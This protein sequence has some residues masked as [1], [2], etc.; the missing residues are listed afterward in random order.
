M[1]EPPFDLLSPEK[2]TKLL[3]KLPEPN[4]TFADLTGIGK[5]A[6]LYADPKHPAPDGWA[7][8]TLDWVAE[9][10]GFED[11]NE[12]PAD[13]WAVLAESA[14]ALRTAA[15]LYA[16]CKQ[17]GVEVKRPEFPEEVTQ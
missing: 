9:T 13:L 5:I 10:Y 1:S 11:G 7:E 4:A 17:A 12:P 3:G 16:L 14:A 2:I 15:Y 6:L 8:N